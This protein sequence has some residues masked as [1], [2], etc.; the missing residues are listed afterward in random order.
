MNYYLHLFTIFVKPV[1][2]QNHDFPYDLPLLTCYLQPLVNHLEAAV[3]YH[4]ISLAVPGY[5]WARDPHA[6]HNKMHDPRGTSLSG[7]KSA[8]VDEEWLTQVVARG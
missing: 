3:V 5:S 8:V 6:C 4:P 7:S 2:F 1:W